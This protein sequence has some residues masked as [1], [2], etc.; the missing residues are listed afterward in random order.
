M[1]LIATTLHIVE[2][3]IMQDPR[4]LELNQTTETIGEIVEAKILQQQQ[5]KTTLEN[6][7]WKVFVEKM[8][9]KPPE[10]DDTHTKEKNTIIEDFQRTGV[11]IL[12][13]NIESLK[14]LKRLITN[15]QY[16][17]TH[18]DLTA[19]FLD[20]YTK[21]L[22]VEHQKSSL[23]FFSKK[24]SSQQK[25]TM[26]TS[27]LLKCITE[28][29][30]LFDA[31]I[32]HEMIEVLSV[33]CGN[34]FSSLLRNIGVKRYSGL[35]SHPEFLKLELKTSLS[36]LL[37]KITKEEFARY[38]GIGTTENSK[39]MRNFLYTRTT[40]ENEFFE[41]E[42]SIFDVMRQDSSLTAQSFLSKLGKILSIQILALFALQ[43]K[44]I[45]SV[46]SQSIASIEKNK[47][48]KTKQVKQQSSKP[49]QN[50]ATHS[51]TNTE[52][53]TFSTPN[54]ELNDDN[55]ETPKT[56]HFNPTNCNSIVSKPN[57]TQ[58]HKKNAATHIKD[59]RLKLKEQNYKYDKALSVLKKVFSDASVSKTTKG[60]LFKIPT[61]NPKHP[62]LYRFREEIDELTEKMQQTFSTHKPHPSESW[63]TGWRH[64]LLEMLDA[65]GWTDEVL[66]GVLEVENPKDD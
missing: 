40:E 34:V 17:Q 30:F 37:P 44:A 38:P 41:G 21:F 6:P 56:T 65:T 43:K 7:N 2:Q 39:V 42:Y 49:E 19:I 36:V 24:A 11:K 54:Q 52:Q 46:A 8:L 58:T 29:I 27:T 20:L 57:I 28:D 9:S 10:K 16:S 51:T 3:P 32:F 53:K 33:S 13:H 23:D 5:F 25:S 47:N 62:M 26:D 31:S 1:F 18:E 59:L 48:T 12:S 50:T 14:L 61:L 66:D 45:E 60:H 55:N 22:V 35:K 15:Y 64:A 4:A 63:K